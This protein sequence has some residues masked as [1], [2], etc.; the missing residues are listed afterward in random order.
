MGILYDA[1]TAQSLF[2]RFKIEKLL[3]FYQSQRGDSGGLIY[4]PDDMRIAG[5]HTA[6]AVDSGYGV[7]YFTPAEAIVSYFGLTL[8]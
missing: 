1:D 5:I 3:T 2:G 6:G 4:T 8:Y 7:R